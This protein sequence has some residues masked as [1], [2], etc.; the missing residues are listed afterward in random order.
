[1]SGEADMPRADERLNLRGV[2][3]P[4]NAARALLRLEG[5]DEGQVLELLIDDGEPLENVPPS[6][7][8]EDHEILLMERVDGQWRLLIRSA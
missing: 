8:Q 3:C 1:M 6:L 2:P 4:A 7:T 5:M